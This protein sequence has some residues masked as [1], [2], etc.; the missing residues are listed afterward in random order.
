MRS[1]IRRALTREFAQTRCPVCKKMGQ[2]GLH[3]QGVAICSGC[4]AS[5]DYDF[6]ERK[7]ETHSGFRWS[8]QL[9]YVRFGI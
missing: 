1:G 3:A 8:I 7:V 6:T 5:I 4:G 9:N 2:I